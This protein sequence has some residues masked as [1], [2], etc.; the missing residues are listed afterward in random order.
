MARTI[1]EPKPARPRD[2]RIIADLEGAG[3]KAGIRSALPRLRPADRSARRRGPSMD[4]AVIHAS[5]ARDR[6]SPLLRRSPQ[7]RG[8][9]PK[10]EAASVL[11]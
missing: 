5:V 8:I 1:A 11:E 3:V 6:R 4:A 9:L 2:A 10:T 7:E